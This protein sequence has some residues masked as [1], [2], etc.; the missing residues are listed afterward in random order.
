MN[1][2]N[3][4]DSKESKRLSTQDSGKAQPLSPQESSQVTAAWASTDHLV[5]DSR[6]SIPDEDQVMNARE[7]VNENQK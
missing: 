4:K 1:D 6:V 5:E 7:F 2:N 3:H